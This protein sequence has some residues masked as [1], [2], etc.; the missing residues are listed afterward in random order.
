[1]AGTEL[2]RFN[3]NQY[4]TQILLKLAPRAAGTY[5]INMLVEGNSLLS[6]V[7]IESADPG[8]SVEV[9]Y[10][11]TTTGSLSGERFDLQDA[12][13]VIAGTAAP[14]TDRRLV[15]KIHNKPVMEAIVTGGS[16]TFGVYVTV[17]QSFATDLDAALQ[18]DSQD[19]DL[20]TDKGMPMM[21]YDEETGKFYFIRCENG[22]IPVSFSEAGDAVHLRYQ[23]VST[24]GIEQTLITSVV[25]AS[26]KRLVNKLIVT[27]RHPGTY[28]LDDGSDIIASGRIGPGNLV[29][30]F[31]FAPRPDYAAGTTL[32]LKYT[33]L[34]GTPASDIEAYFMASDL[35][36]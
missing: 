12:H 2:A 6:S 8:A 9:K 7:F 28:K 18:L 27:G 19:A 29:S 36:V 35:E 14:T 1:M 30:R 34:S 10:Y 13:P 25:P 23:G 21:C 26:K 5:I 24:P 3:L 4:Q 22:V 33:A 15:S 31:V 20:A 11:D 32:T 17:V 16:V